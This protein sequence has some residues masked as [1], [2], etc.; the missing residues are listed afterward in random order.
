[1]D[2]FSLAGQ[3]KIKD[4]SRLG[5]TLDGGMCFYHL[6]V[7]PSRHMYNY[8]KTARP[9]HITIAIASVLLFTIVMFCVYDVLVEKRQRLVM[10]T[11]LRSS[12]IVSS[13]FPIKQIRE[14]L[15]SEAERAGSLS[16]HST[17]KDR[18]MSFLS[19]IENSEESEGAD[20][21]QENKPIASL[22]PETSILFADL[23]GKHGI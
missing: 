9:L 10:T 6:K 15:Y 22:F 21:S 2:S 7:Y 18:L 4:K 20:V 19:G 16:V 12:R 23:A 17:T 8:Y 1:M 14:R 13:A 11:A 3:N 5:Y